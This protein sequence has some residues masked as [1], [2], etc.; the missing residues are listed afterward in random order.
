MFTLQIPSEVIYII[1]SLFLILKLLNLFKTFYK[2]FQNN[3][4][5]KLNYKILLENK[6]CLND[7]G[8]SSQDIKDFIKNNNSYK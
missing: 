4:P 8:F 2:I 1:A 6:K 7:L 3:K 5:I